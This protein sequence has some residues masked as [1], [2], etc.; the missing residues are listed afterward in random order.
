MKRIK[1]I[2]T[3]AHVLGWFLLLPFF[4]WMFY[5]ERVPNPLFTAAV[6]TLISVVVF[7]S[8]FFILTQYF[9]Q[10]K[11]SIYLIGL[12]IILLVCPF[13]YLWALRVEIKEDLPHLV[14]VTIL[15]VIMVF[16]SGLA[17]ATEDWFINL[18]KRQELEKQSLSAELLYLKS[19]INPH[20]LFNTLNNIHAL[21][22]KN[23]P[24]TPEA[25]MRLSS[26]MRYMIYESNAPAVPLTR[27]IEY[28]QDFINLQQLRYKKE[29]LV[30]LE[31]TGDPE[32]C[33]VAPLLFIHLLENAYKHSHSKL[34]VGDIKVRIEIRDNSLTFDIQN[35]LTKHRVQSIDEPGGIGLA[36]VQKRLQLIYPDQHTFEIERTDEYFKVLLTIHQ[37]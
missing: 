29:A 23:S 21:A 34:N 5:G 25:I 17:R 20:F 30:D 4:L 7:Y 13:L 11:F 28:L 6:L 1:N 26:L 8:H 32:M 18:F 24:S 31:I 15:T 16:L 33:R 10:K 14:V 35:P 22:Y 12:L 37:L 19:Q 36:N 2:F 3:I 27:E 9:K